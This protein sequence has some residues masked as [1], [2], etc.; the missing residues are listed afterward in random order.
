VAGRRVGA[1]VSAKAYR[2]HVTLARSRRASV[3]ATPIVD[4]LSSYAGPS[5][6]ASELV[7][8]RSHLGASVR[9]EQVQTWRLGG[10]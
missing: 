7:L 8:V 3:D 10:G 5:W 9:H 1:D 2:P 6:S 4:A